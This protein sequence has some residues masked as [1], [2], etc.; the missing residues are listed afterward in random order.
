[1]LNALE[2]AGTCTPV[3]L[4]RVALI[5]IELFCNALDHGHLH[6]DSS[7]KSSL[8]TFSEYFEQR[9]F[10]LLGLYQGT[11]EIRLKVVGSDLLEIVV[12]HDGEGFDPSTVCS[13]LDRSGQYYGRG[14]AMIRE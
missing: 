11:I 6:L 13:R 3:E 4:N 1:M 7:L 14:I 10:R 8:E 5:L 2:V 9:E 12:S